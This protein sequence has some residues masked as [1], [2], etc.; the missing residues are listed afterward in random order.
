MA[1][2]SAERR[3]EL[4]RSH[5]N[6]TPKEFFERIYGKLRYNCPDA[7]RIKVN[8]ES[9]TVLHWRDIEIMHY[10][11]A[12]EAV[13]YYRFFK[14]REAILSGDLSAENGVAKFK[15]YHFFD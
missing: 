4:F 10:M 11:S 15:E 2:A 8:D 1:L 6:E 12:I 9:Y 7:V 5:P 13:A 3:V 14:L